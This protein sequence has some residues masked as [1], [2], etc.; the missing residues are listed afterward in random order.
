MGAV[1][2]YADDV[3]D[4]T[5]DTLGSVYKNSLDD[6]DG[7]KGFDLSKDFDSLNYNKSFADLMTPE[8]AARYKDWNVQKI[9]E[10][11]IKNP[12][13]DSMTLGKYLD[14]TIDSGS[15]IAKAK[16]TGDTYFDLGDQ[17]WNDVKKAY[18]LNDDE[19]FDLFNKYA[20]DDAVKKGKRIRFSQNPK[21]Y[22][23][24]YLYQEWEY[25]QNNY[26]YSELNFKGE[27]WYAE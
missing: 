7:F 8:E 3:A 14:G 17:F 27:Y 6:V 16:S 18:N 15:Y 2:K 5:D 13:S 21:D 10:I 22:K 23:T 25:L 24:S 9:R 4:L 1:S 20:I 12:N 19:M 11:S 26:G